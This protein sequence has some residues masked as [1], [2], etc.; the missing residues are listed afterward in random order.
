MA[1][2]K[3]NPSGES[4]MPISPEIQALERLQKLGAEEVYGTPISELLQL[5]SQRAQALRQLAGAEQSF[6][7]TQDPTAID[8]SRI[9]G[10]AVEQIESALKSLEG[11][12]YPEKDE[13]DFRRQALA[14]D[15]A[16]ARALQAAIERWQAAQ[17]RLSELEARLA[18]VEQAIQKR[19]EDL[20]K[21]WDQEVEQ[22]RQWQSFSQHVRDFGQA[23]SQPSFQKLLDGAKLA[24]DRA[25]ADLNN[26]PVAPSSPWRKMAGAVLTQ[27][28]EQFKQAQ[29]Q[30]AKARLETATYWLDQAEKCLP[31]ETSTVAGQ[32]PEGEPILSPPVSSISESI[33]AEGL[34]SDISAPQ[35]SAMPSG[36]PFAALAC[37]AR[38]KVILD[39]SEPSLQEGVK[40]VQKRLE[41]L[42]KGA[43]QYL[44][45]WLSMERGGQQKKILQA[46]QEKLN[47]W[48]SSHPAEDI[49]HFLGKTEG[50][51]EH[52]EL[53]D[54]A[55]FH[56]YLAPEAKLDDALQKL[57]LARQDNLLRARQLLGEVKS[58][59]SAAD[60][61]TRRS[62][63]YWSL[64]RLEEA[65]AC[66]PDSEEIQALLN[67]ITQVWE[68]AGRKFENEIQQMQSFLNEMKTTIDSDGL[69]KARQLLDEVERVLNNQIEPPQ[70]WSEQ[71]KEI[72]FRL[73]SLE[74]QYE[75]A[76]KL[77]EQ[78]KV[79]V[80]SRELVE[81]TRMFLSEPHLPASIKS[82][83]KEALEKQGG[84]KHT[85]FR[86]PSHAIECV[87]LLSL[88]S[89]KPLITR[90]P[91]RGTSQ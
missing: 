30:H 6:Y 55:R 66:D 59:W 80:V 62:C 1:E 25:Q 60:E 58:R 82:T 52:R 48:Q 26:W 54:R 36:D 90:Q 23:I 2:I 79:P 43:E 88:L 72:A 33:R 41:E 12:K 9:M 75:R 5:A 42:Q 8:A 89:Q 19:R 44:S 81:K 13:F 34:P 4:L 69:K 86:Q 28:E 45:K 22:I 87:E 24:I 37:L 77:K 61:Q 29:E 10:D 53:V 83:I 74:E 14:A 7:Q 51:K 67:K 50:E 3:M 11:I 35:L 56:L 18:A 47:N 73:S 84:Y 68:E 71:F 64:R 65:K 49:A 46:L 16:R 78:W 63:A 76:Q 17:K 31:D 38:A 85:H 39:E 91:V 20:E 15:I 40:E 27:M 21:Q 70:E 32:V 57:I